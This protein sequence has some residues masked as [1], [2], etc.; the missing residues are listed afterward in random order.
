LGVAY[1]PA[2]AVATH[3]FNGFGISYGY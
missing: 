2:A 1:S 3:S